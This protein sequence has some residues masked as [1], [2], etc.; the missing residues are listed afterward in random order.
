[1]RTNDTAAPLG[2][3]PPS[4]AQ[5]RYTLLLLTLASS[6]AWLD[7]SIV[8]I[9]LDPIKREI[10]VNDSLMGL[11]NGLGFSLLYAVLAIPVARLADRHNRRNILTI[12]LAVWSF[13]TILCGLSHNFVQ[14]LA[15]RMG[16]GAA[17]SAASAPAQS[18]LTDCFPPRLRPAA[19]GVYASSLYIGVSCAAL[20]GGY[21]GSRFGWR[22]ALLASGF[23]GIILAITMAL[24][25]GEPPRGAHDLKSDHRRFRF[26]EAMIMLVREPAL[27]LIIA[28]MALLAILNGAAMV[29][30]PALLGRVYHL[31]LFQIGG[32]IALV[33]GGGGILGSCGGGI[34]AARISK[35]DIATQQAICAVVVL[36]AM[37]ALFVI[38]AA[39]PIVAAV[40][41]M[42]TFATLMGMPIGLSFA[43]VQQLAPQNVRALAAAVTTLCTTLI[44]VGGGPL[45]VGIL[46]DYF[47]PVYHL[48]GVRFA[49]RALLPIGI[50]GALFYAMSWRRL[51]RERHVALS[52]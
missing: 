51:L 35:G 23:P 49:L 41:A 15:T 28:A 19:F 21:L 33:Q 17:E 22:I 7:R 10:E 24:T 5:A 11:L 30:F 1:M 2:N 31:D 48:E 18:M 3:L 47:T 6:F 42:F 46:S 27:I 32:T 20:L 44:G 12:G 13:M 34:I 16:V 50:A 43:G 38:T 37:P 26:S 25:M 52:R 36:L 4:P 8:P 9:L 39:P 40:T 14:L 29:W 45:I